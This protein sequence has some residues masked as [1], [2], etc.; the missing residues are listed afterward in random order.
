MITLVSTQDFIILVTTINIPEEELQR[1]YYGISFVPPRLLYRTGR[2]RH[3]WKYSHDRF[4]LDPYP[5]KVVGVFGHPLNR[6]WPELGPRIRDLLRA[7]NVPYSSIDVARFITKGREYGD[8]EIRG[9]VL[10]WIAVSPN[11]LAI[12][13]VA[14]SAEAVLDLLIEYGIQDVEIEYRE[15]TYRRLS[16]RAAVRGPLTSTLGLPIAGSQSSD[17]EGT[18]TLYFQEGEGNDK[19]FGLTCRHVL[20]PPT[21]SQPN[22]EN[23]AFDDADAGEPQKPVM[24][25]GTKGFERLLKSVGSEIR[26]HE[27]D[28][29]FRE[30]EIN[31]HE[32]DLGGEHDEEEDERK[33]HLRRVM[34][35]LEHG[36]SALAGLGN[37]EFLEDWAVIEIDERRFKPTLKGNFIDLDGV[38]LGTSFCAGDLGRAMRHVQ[39]QDEAQE[40]FR[41]P[42]YR[43]LPLRDIMSE[44][45]LLSPDTIAVDNKEPCN[46]VIKSGNAT[47]VTIGLPTGCFSFV[48]DVK[49]GEDGMAWAVFNYTESLFNGREMCPLFSGPGDSGAVI[50]DGFGKIGGV[51]VG[52]T[53]TDEDCPDIS[54]ATPMFWLWPR[55]LKHFPDAR[56]YPT[57]A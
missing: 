31:G 11:S 17:Q 48:R 24:L 34:Q 56:L 12:D 42:L 33:R 29:E 57:T 9:P 39:P 27:S 19:I 6:L 10:I 52:A 28:I 40:A 50:V 8:P 18:L 2:D 54:Y 53:G 44:Q 13:D 23:K 25:L 14:W 55:V 36:R 22:N 46:L 5:K 7:Q 32:E 4:S 45:I 49:T 35:R 21:G 1:Y 20:L 51:L 3:P 43:L 26:H 37:Q 38:V 30:S 15:S 16:S 47:G 41:Y